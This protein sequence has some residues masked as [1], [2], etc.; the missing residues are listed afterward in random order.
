[1]LDPPPKITDAKHIAIFTTISLNMV[2]MDWNPFPCVKSWTIFWQTASKKTN[3]THKE[4][5]IM[6]E[7]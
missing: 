7:I 1:M 4:R 6:E 2:K 3:A 5:W